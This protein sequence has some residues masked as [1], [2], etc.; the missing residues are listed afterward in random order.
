[1]HV[2]GLDIGYSNVKIVFG[3]PDKDPSSIVFPAGAGLVEN[4]PR[5]I[6]K[7]SA[8]TTVTLDGEQWITGVNPARFEM[9]SRV[10]HTNYPSTREYKA[11]FYSALARAGLAEIDVLVTGLPVDQYLD[12]A[13]KKS[14]ERMLVGEHQIAPKRNVMVK[15]I[16]RDS[17]TDRGLSG[18]ALEHRRRQGS[19]PCRTLPRPYH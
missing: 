16:G 5:Q 3:S 13:E 1:M 11:L 9:A 8:V 4:Y 10:L 19:C 17:P 14:L 7:K 18:Y 12:D 2:L 15:K 6:G